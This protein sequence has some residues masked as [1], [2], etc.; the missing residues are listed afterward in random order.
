[1]DQDPI[2]LI[3]VKDGKVVLV[4]VKRR[5]SRNMPVE[6]LAISEAT[7][8]S[9]IYVCRKNRKNDLALFWRTRP[10]NIGEN[11]ANPWRSDFYIWLNILSG[12]H[13]I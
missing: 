7:K 12:R 9:A 1:M 4:E 5:T 2:D 11:K 6:N 10:R 3:L 8:F 13:V